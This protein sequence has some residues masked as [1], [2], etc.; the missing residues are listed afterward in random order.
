MVKGDSMNS[1]EFDAMRS[2]A[3]QQIRIAVL[4]ELSLLKTEVRLMSENCEIATIDRYKVDELLD[5]RIDF[6]EKK[7]D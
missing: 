5:K 2:Y 3:R 7:N 1:K 6:W 4:R